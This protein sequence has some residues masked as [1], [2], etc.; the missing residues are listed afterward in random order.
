MEQVTA[1]A[2]QTGL[3]DTLVNSLS[4]NPYFNAGA[5]LAGIGFAAALSKRFMIVGN[6]LL[7]RRFITSLTLSNED[8]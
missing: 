3:I 4:A 8:A 1:V 7:R 5:G 6:T 2:Q